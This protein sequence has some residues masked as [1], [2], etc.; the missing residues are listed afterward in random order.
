MDKVILVVGE[1]TRDQY[2]IIRQECMRSGHKP[3]VKR[4]SSNDY[5]QSDA[6]LLMNNMPVGRNDAQL[7]KAIVAGA[8]EHVA[9]FGDVYAVVMDQAS[10]RVL[11]RNDFAMLERERKARGI[12][13]WYVDDN[14]SAYID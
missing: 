5:L 1:V 8:R 12:T 14:G 2:Q 6:Q 3:T 4:V 13:Q 11:D 9:S 10:W 7:N